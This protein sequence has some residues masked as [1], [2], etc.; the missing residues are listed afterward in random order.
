MGAYKSKIVASN[1]KNFKNK[2]YSFE[3]P[4]YKGID[5]DNLQDWINL[6]KIYKLIG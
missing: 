1:F 6:K 2:Y 5:V 4:F 3:I